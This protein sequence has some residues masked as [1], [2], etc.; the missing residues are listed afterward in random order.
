MLVDVYGSERLHRDILWVPLWVQE[1]QSKAEMALRR[2]QP[3]PWHSEP[4]MEDQSSYRCLSRRG[5]TYNCS[6]TLSSL[7]LQVLVFFCH[8][9]LKGIQIYRGFFSSIIVEFHCHLYRWVRKYSTATDISEHSSFFFLEKATLDTEVNCGARQH[10][11]ERWKRYSSYYD[12]GEDFFRSGLRFITASFLPQ[13][14]VSQFSSIRK[15]RKVWAVDDS[16][17]IIGTIRLTKVYSF[18]SQWLFFC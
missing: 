10:G 16:C 8:L 14:P 7:G 2:S 1:G 4:W 17:L 5:E 6:Q 13:L 15:T 12:Y 9:S 11:L 3:S 18:V